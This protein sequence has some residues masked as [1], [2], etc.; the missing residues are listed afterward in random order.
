MRTVVWCGLLLWLA[1]SPA[2]AQVRVD[3]RLDKPRYLAGE[4]VVVFVDVR[5]VGDEAVG[6]ST[7][8]GDVRLEVV[9]ARRRVPP[10][11][12]GCSSGIGGGYACGEGHPPLLQPGQTTTFRY[13]LKEYDLR[14]GRHRLSASGKAGVRWKY[15]PTYAPSVA[16]PPPKHKETDPVDGAQFATTLSL[17]VVAATEREL[18]AVL[19]PLVSDADG[20]DPARRH[21]AREAIIESAPSFLESLIA[22]FAA[23]NPNVT[24]AIDALG[25]IAS[26]GSRMHLKELLRSSREARSRSSIL[27]ALARVGHR[28]DADFLA[29]VLEDDTLDETSW[30]HAALGVGRAGGGRA[31]QHLE[32]ALAAA[33][34]GQRPAIATA[35]G[36]TRSRAAVPVLIG[37]FSHDASAND[38][39]RGL[40][41]LT[42]RVWC[43]GSELDPADTQRQWLRW[44]QQN[45]ATMRIFGSDRCPAETA[46]LRVVPIRSERSR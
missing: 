31:V 5:N 41:T 11:I 16:P 9:G 14:P 39:C 26:S 32:R 38:V 1:G 43:V 36:N 6:Y 8:D 27:L 21:Y 46:R 4:P 42:H 33:S 45:G 23:E 34:P 2:V 7:C 17:N 18:R 13:L 29:G 28:D 22:R 12:H 44:W 30:S 35:L 15:Y 20:R 19:A 10:N 24:S 3:V 37:M 40:I 25:R